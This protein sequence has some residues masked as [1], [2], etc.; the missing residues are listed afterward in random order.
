MLVRRCCSELSGDM[1]IEDDYRAREDD[2]VTIR[3]VRRRE[4]KFSGWVVEKNPDR[5]RSEVVTF[6]VCGRKAPNSICK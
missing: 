5:I 2:P 6:Y 4:I 3:C 1:V